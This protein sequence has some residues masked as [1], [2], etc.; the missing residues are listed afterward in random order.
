L[1]SPTSFNHKSG[2][3]QQISNFTKIGTGGVNRYAGSSVSYNWNDGTPTLTGNTTSGVWRSGVGKGF[4]ITVPADTTDKI[5]KLYVS[6]W[7]AEG[8]LEVTL[9]DGSAPTYV[10]TL[11]STGSGP[12]THAV[13][14]LN[15]RA[16]SAGQT[17][18]I[19]W[20]VLSSSSGS[21]NVTM[22][23]ATLR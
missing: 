17:L 6:A 5:L 18:T 1:T 14:T 3:P 7:S 2:V 9:S 4:Q 10:D 12:N 23:A 15:Y 19:R 22:Q 8:R 13:Y 16:A 21:G 20:T 11:S